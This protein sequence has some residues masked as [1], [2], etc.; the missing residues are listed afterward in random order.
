MSN[1]ADEL[2]VASSGHIWIAP[3][4]VTLPAKNS[5][6]TTAPNAAFADLGYLTEDGVKPTSSPDISDFR[7]WQARQAVRRERKGQDLQF[8]FSL[9]QW[10]PTTV[11]F[12]FGGGSVDTSG[13]FPTYTFPKARDALAEWAFLLDWQDGDKNFRWVLPRGNVTDAVSPEFKADA[14]AV[15]PVTFKGLEAIDGTDIYM[16]TDDPDWTDGS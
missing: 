5:D 3:V 9:E 16:I 12:A 14:L 4:G 2:V 7:A 1:N 6:P 15:L 13:G 11:K 8:E 10:N